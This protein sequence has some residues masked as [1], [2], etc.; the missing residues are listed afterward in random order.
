MFWNDN[1]NSLGMILEHKIGILMIGF[2]SMLFKKF[3]EGCNILPS[4]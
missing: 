3:K 4:R 1:I 2:L